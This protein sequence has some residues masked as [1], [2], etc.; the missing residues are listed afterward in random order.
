MIDVFLKLAILIICWHGLVGCEKKS[1]DNP[2]V[3]IQRTKPSGE[4]PL[5]A[6]DE[7]N[8]DIGI[9]TRHAPEGSS[10]GLVIQS[11][12]DTLLGIAEPIQVKNG[13]EI[14][15]S[16]KTLI[17]LTTAVNV[18]AALYENVNKDSIAVDSRAFKVVGIK[19]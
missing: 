3:A 4:T 7:V 10:V 12:D 1:S 9:L 19:K 6:G 18:Y 5:L 13:Q 14:Q 2:T 11:S 8:F 17:P 16:V 15:L